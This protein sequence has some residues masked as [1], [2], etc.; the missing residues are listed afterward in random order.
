MRLPQACPPNGP[1]SIS[2][3]TTGLTEGTQALV[4]RAQD[5]AGNMG[6]SAPVTARI[7]N[8]APARVDT[9]VEGGDQWRN[10]NDFALA[11]TN[12]TEVDRAPIAAAAYKLCSAGAGSCNQGEQ[13][14][15]AISRLA[16]QAQDR[17]SGPS[18]CG[19]V[20]PRETRIRP[21]RRC[22]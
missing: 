19:G 6:D 20:T 5:T 11:W 18:R 7:D 21:L 8:S 14:G 12:P 2:V 10:S 9:S 1:G 13:A 16:V 22:R 17:A 15:E 4:V 3:D